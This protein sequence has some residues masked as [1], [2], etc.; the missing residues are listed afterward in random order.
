MQAQLSQQRCDRRPMLPSE[1][2]GEDAEEYVS[3]Q[4]RASPEADNVSRTAPASRA[5]GPGHGVALSLAVPTVAEPGADGPRTLQLLH[6]VARQSATALIEGSRVRADNKRASAELDRARTENDK[7]IAEVAALRAEGS[8]LEHR[9]AAERQAGAAPHGHFAIS[10]LHGPA[11][12]IAAEWHDHR[13]LVLAAAVLLP[14]LLA[15]LWF[16]CCRPHKPKKEKGR[17]TLD[18]IKRK[19]RGGEHE[20]DNSEDEHAYGQRAQTVYHLLCGCS[21]HA[22]FDFYSVLVAWWVGF[23]VMWHFGV[24][25]P[26]LQQLIVVVM[27]GTLLLAMLALTSL[28]TWMHV[29]GKFHKVK[30][31][32]KKGEKKVLQMMEVAGFE[33][34][35]GGHSEGGGGGEGHEGGGASGEG[36]SGAEGKEG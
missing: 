9:L 2:G 34:H 12:L 32:L 14:V 7:V 33:L 19:T 25:Q 20:A 16:L 11:S 35:P 17:G 30:V 6:A 4:L 1:A 5:D 13:R 3:L 28:E 18:G 29:R 15:S 36:G 31:W 27:M 26:F 8:R 21:P 24:V 23:G 22:R 10:L